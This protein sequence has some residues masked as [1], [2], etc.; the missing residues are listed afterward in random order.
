M[1][2]NNRQRR[3]AKAKRRRQ[4]HR[5]QRP[6]AEHRPQSAT[7]VRELFELA[8]VATLNGQ[9]GPRL[10]A[11][12]TLERLEP[13]LVAAEAEARLLHFVGRMWEIGWQPAELVRHV[14]RR[15]A[16]AVAITVVG[17]SIAADRLRHPPGTV[18]PRWS[19]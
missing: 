11:V 8:A 6:T 5:Q 2:I 14:R 12:T 1:G 9:L 10:Q 16:P 17:A 19:A 18:D 3:A 4:D 7:A 13:G 15:K